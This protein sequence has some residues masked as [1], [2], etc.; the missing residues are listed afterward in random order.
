[1]VII[2]FLARSQL[3]QIDQFHDKDQNPL[4]PKVRA[5]MVPV[6]DVSPLASDHQLRE[7][8]TDVLQYLYELQNQGIQ[9]FHLGLIGP[10][11]LAFFLGQQL[12]AWTISLYEYY[13]DQ[14]QYQY[15]FDLSE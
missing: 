2:D 13:S 3:S 4:H 6:G 15:V 9:R 8:L 5:R 11:V 14:S 1:M 10:D 7:V 12:N